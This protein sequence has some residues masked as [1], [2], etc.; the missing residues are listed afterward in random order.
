[1]KKNQFLVLPI[2][3]DQKGGRPEH[4]GKWERRQ[5]IAKLGKVFGGGETGKGDDQRELGLAREWKEESGV[6]I[7]GS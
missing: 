6:M 1:M 2:Q 7:E 5:A 4:G 3:I